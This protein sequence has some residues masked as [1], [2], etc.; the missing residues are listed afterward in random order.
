M[1]VRAVGDIIGRGTMVAQDTSL[2]A[3]VCDVCAYVCMCM[4]APPT[5]AQTH[6]ELAPLQL[7]HLQGLVLQW[8]SVHMY[9][10]L[11]VEDELCHPLLPI[12]RLVLL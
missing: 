7:S 1:P 10:H 5:D 8:N 4:C 3:R 12:P 9:S 11:A 6:T 2:C